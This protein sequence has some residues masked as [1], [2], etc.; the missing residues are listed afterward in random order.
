MKKWISISLATVLSLSCLTGC[1]QGGEESSQQQTHNIKNIIVLIGDGM[2][3]THVQAGEAYEEKDYAF[4]NWHQTLVDTT[5]SEWGTNY[6]ITDSAAGA[7]AIA[8]GT[9]TTNGR[10]GRDAD[11]KD[12]QTVMDI[13]KSQ[14]KATAVVS[15]DYLYGATP[16]AFSGHAQTRDDYDDIIQSQIISSNVDLLC[17]A[18]SS[19]TMSEQI[20][21]LVE[22]N[23]YAYCDDTSYIDSTMQGEKAYW[24]LD[25]SLLTKTTKALEFVSRD[26]DGFVMMLEQA[27]I[28]KCSHSADFDGMVKSVADLNATVDMLL[29][30]IGDRTDTAILVTADHETGKLK[31]VEEYNPYIYTY[32]S[33]NGTDIYYNFISDSHSDKLVGLYTYGIEPDFASFATY[34]KNTKIKNVETG[35]IVKN[36]LSDPTMY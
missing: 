16:A 33:V 1:G 7:T 32:Q 31:I 17:G 30:W 5:S 22:A 14:G 25:G 24:Q 6:A 21:D 29:N 36:L 20:Q 35:I 23:G 12:L 13:A 2:G 11:G 18:Q 34:G 26:E 27:H 4:T 28:D 19:L 9:L 3:T 15:T 8:T 10:V